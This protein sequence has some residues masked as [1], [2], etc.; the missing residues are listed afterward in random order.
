MPAALARLLFLLVLLAFLGIRL[1]FRR[2]KEVP[3]EQRRPGRE[4]LLTRTM[5]VAVVF[6][7]VLWIGSPWLR[8]ADLP[9]PA[10]V[11][12]L[13]LVLAALGLCGLGWSH[14]ALGA[15]FS[16][17]LEIRAEHGLIVRGPYRWVRHPMYLA[18]LVQVLGSGLLTGNLVVLLWPLANLALLLALRLPEEERMLHERFGPAWEAWAARTGRLFPRVSGA[19]AAPPK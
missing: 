6:S 3:E 16:P 19:G 13:G 17:W 4:R 18:G 7:A 11:G 15:N 12:W 1:A 10:A 8:F 2:S 9:L 5:T 14:A